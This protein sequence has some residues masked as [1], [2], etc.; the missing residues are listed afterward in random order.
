[1]YTS[2]QMPLL[3]HLST[4]QTLITSHQPEP[5][6][7]IISL[8]MVLG[9]IKV[10]VQGGGGGG[11]ERRAEP[12]RRNTVRADDY[13]RKDY[14]RTYDNVPVRA[15]YEVIAPKLPRE[16][17]ESMVPR[18]HREHR[19]VYDDKPVR[20]HYEVIAPKYPPVRERDLPA[21]PRGVR[22]HVRK[23]PVSAHRQVFLPAPTPLPERVASVAPRGRREQ[24]KHHQTTKATSYHPNHRRGH[25]A[26]KHHHEPNKSI[27]S[28]Y[29]EIKVLG[30]GGQGECH[31]MERRSD[32]KKYVR[33]ISHTFMKNKSTGKP[34]EA[35]ILQ[36]VL[37]EHE[38]SI[39]LIEYTIASDSL[40]AIYDFY[41]G[42]DLTSY[43]PERRGR[44]S[45][46]FVW[47]IF[48][49]L[50]D[51]LAY[52]HEGF[53][54][55]NPSRAPLDWQ[56]VIHCDIKPDNVFLRDLPHSTSY[57][58]IVLGDFGF[59]TLKPGRYCSG[60]KAYYSPEIEETGNTKGSDVWALGATIHELVLGYAPEGR[61]GDALPRGYSDGL[62]EVVGACLRRDPSCRISARGLVQRVY[63]E[64]ERWR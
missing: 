11:Q 61:R 62:D 60:T 48:V 43:L 22:E 36:D 52:L 20:A 49:Q 53:D 44:P 8:E 33:K 24:P 39:K 42:G 46:R 56:P 57:P 16:R 45:E 12:Q 38:R 54:H 17:K 27:A 64:Y 10:G 29:R 1:M 26:P 63:K 7:S 32:G 47:W 19:R 35:Y 59:A 14:P 37:R 55:K 58:N 18:G 21:A 30:E 6:Q 40:I 5:K 41:P 2:I 31:L 25:E 28:S 13:T 51:V 15:H 50:A 23:A 9:F 4:T 34:T 3:Q